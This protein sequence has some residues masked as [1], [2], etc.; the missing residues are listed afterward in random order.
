MFNSGKEV[1]N[2]LNNLEPI[3]YEYVRENMGDRNV[4][5][6]LREDRIR[7]KSPKRIYGDCLEKSNYIFTY[8]NNQQV[9]TGVLLVGEAGAGKTLMAETICNIALSNKLPVIYVRGISLDKEDISFISNIFNNC[10]MFLD[11]FGKMANRDVQEMFLSLLTD[12]SKHILWILTENGIDSISRFLINRPGRIRYY[13]KFGKLD[14]RVVSEYLEDANINKMFKEELLLAYKN[15]SNFTFDFLESLV[16]EHKFCPSKSLADMILDM[17]VKALEVKSKLSVLA[18][19]YLGHT[20]PYVIRFGDF[21]NAIIEM[22]AT[23][24]TNSMARS[25]GVPKTY[26]LFTGNIIINSKGLASSLTLI[27]RVRSS[28]TLE[29]SMFYPDDLFGNISNITT[30]SPSPGV[31]RSLYQ[32]L[33]E[34][35]N[36]VSMQISINKDLLADIRFDKIQPADIDS[37]DPGLLNLYLTGCPL[38]LYSSKDNTKPFIDIK[39]NSIT[40]GEFKFTAEEGGYDHPLYGRVL[41]YT[42]G[43]LTFYLGLVDDEGQPIKVEF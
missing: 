1:I 26:K 22:N 19:E 30:N 20:I 10:V 29:T 6:F 31:N 37:L 9:S 34:E 14:Y 7:F 18:I 35:P 11:E 28:Y 8:F 2:L 41:K 24:E 39:G 3:V 13:L 15:A 16:E 36:R 12:K 40:D 27:S 5:R 38:V 42:C 17:N 4:R 23:P 21:R 32:N 25:M 33:L 43:P